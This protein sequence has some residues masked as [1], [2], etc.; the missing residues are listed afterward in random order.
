M[1]QPALLRGLLNWQLFLPTGPVPPCFND[2][3]FLHQKKKKRYRCILVGDEMG[4]K[5]H[6]HLPGREGR[7]REAHPGSRPSKSKARR[8][9]VCRDR[10][11]EHAQPS[12]SLAAGSWASQRRGLQAC[13]EEP[14]SSI[15]FLDSGVIYDDR[16][17]AGRWGRRLLAE[18]LSTPR[19]VN[20]TGSHWQWVQRKCWRPTGWGGTAVGG[21]VFRRRQHPHRLTRQDPPK[22]NRDVDN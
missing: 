11:G 13:H 6:K 9:A 8:E 10:W 21:Q 3:T 17:A 14:L 22:V 16:S 4:N 20:H 12:A 15:H 2:T 1:A 7:C 5:T 19:K 18:V